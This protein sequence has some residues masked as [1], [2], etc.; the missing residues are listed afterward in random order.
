M[1]PLYTEGE[2]VNWYFLACIDNECQEYS[3][4]FSLWPTSSLSN[5]LSAKK[6]QLH[7]T[8]YIYI[9]YFILVLFTLTKIVNLINVKKLINLKKGQFN[10]LWLLMKW[11]TLW[12]LKVTFSSSV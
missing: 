2:S 6:D 1:G 10:N 9:A 5:T 4:F 11:S 3:N 12:S 8:T 7:T